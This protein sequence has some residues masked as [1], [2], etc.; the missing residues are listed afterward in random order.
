MQKRLSLL[1]VILIVLGILGFLSYQMVFS[2]KSQPLA[3]TNSGPIT[4]AP[5]SFDLEVQNPDNE[6]LTYDKSILVSGKTSPNATV[7]ISNADNDL[8]LSANQ[9]GDFSQVV[10]LS[11]GLNR[12]SVNAFDEIGN[13]KQ[14][15]RTIFYS[16]E[17]IQ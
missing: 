17:Q 15:T 3:L 9:S 5:V 16:E 13:T 7:I 4:Q 2:Q 10:T 11:A 14:V 1:A 6:L 8:A 12:I